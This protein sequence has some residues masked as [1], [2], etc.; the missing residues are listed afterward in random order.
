MEGKNERVKIPPRKTRHV[1]FGAYGKLRLYLTM[2]LCTCGLSVFLSIFPEHLLAILCI[3]VLFQD[4]LPVC[5]LEGPVTYLQDK[6]T[7][8]HDRQLV[9]RGLDRSRPS[10][11]VSPSQDRNVK[12]TAYTLEKKHT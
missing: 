2:F 6:R 11:Q 9:C 12:T 5:V 10:S 7:S 4:V 1:R 3:P 8:D